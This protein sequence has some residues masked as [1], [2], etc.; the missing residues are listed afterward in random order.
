MLSRTRFTKLSSVTPSIS[1]SWK[2]AALDSEVSGHV[3]WTPI[4]LSNP[5]IGQTTP[6]FRGVL[7]RLST[8][9]KKVRVRVRRHTSKSLS[10]LAKSIQKDGIRKADVRLYQSEVATLK[11]NSSK[12]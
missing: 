11:P 10:C 4:F 2:E 12:G 8:G 9:Q 6:P 3:H 1:F 5:V 7:S